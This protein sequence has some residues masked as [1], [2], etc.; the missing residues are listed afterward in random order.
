MKKLI[1]WLLIVAFHEQLYHEAKKG[2]YFNNICSKNPKNIVLK[3]EYV[4]SRFCK[5]YKTL[6]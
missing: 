5:R 4:T 1:H 6:S 3:G 2:A